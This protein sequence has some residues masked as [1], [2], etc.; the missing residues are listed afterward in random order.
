[1]KTVSPVSEVDVSVYDTAGRLLE[2]TARSDASGNYRLQDVP[3][4]SVYV[5][6]QPGPKSGYATQF[7]NAV[8]TIGNA[9]AVQ[10][11]SGQTATIDFL[12]A[13]AGW[14]EGKVTNGQGLPL[15]GI[16]LDLDHFPSGNRVSPGAST[17]ADGTF[18][19]GPLVPGN[20]TLRCD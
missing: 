19:L 18:V 1:M 2:L 13:G 20:Y 11:A 5:R 9:T 16:D 14:I 3:S 17:R 15:A 7:Y 8:E 12:L 6:A 4:G 10:V